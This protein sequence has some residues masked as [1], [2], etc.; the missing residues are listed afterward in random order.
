MDLAEPREDRESPL[1]LGSASVP[2]PCS[3]PGTSAVL[4]GI[5]TFSVLPLLS[6]LPALADLPLQLASRIHSNPRGRTS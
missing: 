5:L 6:F 2:S 3:A 1:E 4:L